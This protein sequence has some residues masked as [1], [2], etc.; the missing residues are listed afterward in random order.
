MKKLY[1]LLALLMALTSCKSAKNV[2]QRSQKKT[3]AILKKENLSKEAASIINYAKRF[4][5]VKYLYGGA[6]KKGMDCSGLIFTSFKDNGFNVPRT[7]AQLSSYGDWVDIKNVKP[8]DLVFF[9]TKKNSRNINHV[10]IVTTTANNTITF[11][12]ASSSKGVIESSLT[13]TYWYFAYVQ[14]RRV[15]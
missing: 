1:F 3:P 10:G 4:K 2:S 15:L 8:G 7:T 14:T 9:A 13:N 6:S 5:G 12:H 11:I